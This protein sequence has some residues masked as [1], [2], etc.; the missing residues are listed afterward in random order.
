[1]PERIKT[2]VRVGGRD[3]LLIHTLDLSGLHPLHGTMPVNVPVGLEFPVKPVAPTPDTIFALSTAPGRAAIAVIRMSGPQAGVVLKTMTGSIPRPR[4]ASL[5]LIRHPV[6]GATLD[7]AL[8]IYFAAPHSETGEDIAELQ[9]HGGRAVIA[10]VLDALDEVPGCRSALPGEFARRA[11]D[12]GKLDL[13]AAEGLIDLIDAETVGQRVQAL[14]QA[15][16]DLYRLYQ[17]WRERLIEAQALVEAGIDFADEGD[18]GTNAFRQATTRVVTLAGEAAA[19]LA[20]A[21]RGEILRDGFRVAI[22]GPPN[23]GKSSLLNTLA[24]REAAIVSEEAG[25]TRDVIEVHLNLGGIPVVVSD[26]AGLRDTDGRIEQ[27]GMRRALASAKAANLVIWLVDAAEPM[28]PLPEG[29]GS[30]ADVLRVLNKID[31]VDQV[32]NGQ[33]HTLRISAQRGDGIARLIDTIIARAQAALGDE[34]LAPTQPRHREHLRT[35]LGHLETFL[36][37]NEDQLEL[38][39]EDL[40]QAAV[41]LG[42]ITGRVDPEDVLDQIFSR[43]CIGK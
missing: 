8:V 38:R 7:Q 3:D 35:C 29:L 32:A 43:F 2:A 21:Q 20:S 17:S 14:R 22:V 31:R 40:R 5:R 26:T 19:H 23:A 34:R 1:M 37:G 28:V 12:H 9:V 33:E 25:T 10:A 15:S 41:S 42:R 27:E 13:T 11:F 6:T 30:D 39:A 18:V 36:G 4:E 16:G 24:R